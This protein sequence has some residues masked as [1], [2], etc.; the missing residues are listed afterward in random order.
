L[1]APQLA[2]SVAV[3]THVEPQQ[4]APAQSVPARQAL[5]SAHVGQ[6]PPPQS[7]SVSVPFFTVSEHVAAWQT[8]PV[9][10]PLSQSAATAHARLA[11]HGVHEPPQSTSVSVPSFI[12]SV[13]LAAMQAWPAQTG[14]AGVQSVP[15]LQPTH[16]PARAGLDGSPQ[17]PVAHAPL[18]GT[19][20]GVDGAEAPHSPSWHASMSV[21]T[22]VGSSTLRVPLTVPS[23]STAWQSP[24]VCKPG[25]GVPLGSGTAVQQCAAVLHL[26]AEQGPGRAM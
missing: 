7:T 26:S 10:T 22:S 25:A 17:T 16:V 1:H 8:R 13:Q 12:L 9:H 2:A 20:S 24:A 19:C 15:S 3:F 4:P 14:A 23:H 18:L 6:P 11:A 5:P 21:G